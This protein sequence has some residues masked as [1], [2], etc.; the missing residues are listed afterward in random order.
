M[1]SNQEE[2]NKQ[3]EKKLLC[4]KAGSKLSPGV[5]GFRLSWKI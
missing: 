2:I 1:N 3:E 4:P 5:Y